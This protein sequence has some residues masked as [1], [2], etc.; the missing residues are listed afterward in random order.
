MRLSL[1]A[2]VA[3]CLLVAPAF[4]D[5][6]A[7]AKRDEGRY[8]VELTEIMLSP[9][10]FDRIVADVD[11]D[12]PGGPAPREEIDATL[13]DP[14][15]GSPRVTIGLNRPSGKTS[16]FISYQDFDPNVSRLPRELRAPGQVVT[17]DY[18]PPGIVFQRQRPGLPLESND[19]FVPNW[20]EEYG[21][22]RRVAFK[23]T[24]AGVQH[25]I[26]ENKN[27]RLRW[28]GGLRHAS[29]VEKS[30]SGLIY[31]PEGSL[32]NSPEM[33]DFAQI[34]SEAS[35]HGI[36][37][38]VGLV[39]RGLLGK[40]KKWSLDGSFD[41]ALIPE[42]T[43]GSYHARFVDS[44]V[45]CIDIIPDPLI[46]AITCFASV[47]RPLMPGLDAPAGPT[48]LASA[49]DG[50]VQQQDFTEVTWLAQAQLG[51]RYQ[52]NDTFTFGFDW[53]GMTWMNL[54]S[55]PGIVD[56]INEEATYEQF[57]PSEESTDPALRDVES[58]IHV[59][60]FSERHDVAFDGIAL[61]LKF[62]F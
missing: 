5:D 60:R 30:T 61:N 32:P 33:Q 22:V 14:R 12:G 3:T 46:V 53:W 57:Y 6:E 27:V 59:P 40:K 62:E 13:S 35:T 11:P 4:A 15:L 20:G 10:D 29:I 26:F 17:T 23:T 51:F 38:D 58:V 7:P 42:S 50:R 1:S 16:I 2:L 9:L 48:G 8:F 28:I 49:F 24:Q 43:T 52:V 25:N 21:Y 54:L 39:F 45:T 37:P 44:E 31:S 56:T 41:V 47:E 18:L 55:E 36:G 34:Q 19:D